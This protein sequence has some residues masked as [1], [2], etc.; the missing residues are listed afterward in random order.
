MARAARKKPVPNGVA[1]VFG[2]GAERGLGAALARRFAAEGLA[3]VIAA[4][5]GDRL[6]ALADRL[7]A[8]GPKIAA[9]TADAGR[10]GDVERVLDRAEALG[11]LELVV[12]NV[13]ANRAA[14]TLD[15]DADAF[16]ALWRQNALAGYVVGRASARRL[17]ARG[18]GTLLFT[19]ATASLRARPPFVGFAAAKAALRAVAQGLAREFGPGGIHVAHVVIDGVIDGAYARE[20]FPAFVASRGADGLVDPDA[21]AEVYWSLHRQPPS[22]WTQEIDLRPFREPF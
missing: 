18:R 16:E 4:R 15:L 6:T 3:V 10:P 9:V 7:D 21:A 1:V 8:I 5:D 22:A 12:F 14:P 17:L 11:I 19:G 2:A 13:G 20:A